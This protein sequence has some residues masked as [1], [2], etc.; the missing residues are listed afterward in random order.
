[1]KPCIVAIDRL[2]PI[3]S[4]ISD[5]DHDRAFVATFQ[6]AYEEA[7]RALRSPVDVCNADVASE[8]IKALLRNVNRYVGYVYTHIYAY[9]HTYKGVVPFVGQIRRS[10]TRETLH[11]LP[12]SIHM[13]AK[14][15]CQSTITGNSFK[16]LS[17][18]QVYIPFF[19]AS[20]RHR[21]SFLP[22]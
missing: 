19:G 7:L 2:R 14:H 18:H 6:G 3:F 17:M 20:P 22:L 11:V 8:P 13:H 15:A 9:I 4:K 12:G 16:S 10:Y 1:M 21:P 5:C